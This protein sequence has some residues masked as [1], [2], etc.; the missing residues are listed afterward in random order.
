MTRF[1]ANYVSNTFLN[2]F[3]STLLGSIRTGKAGAQKR[4]ISNTGNVLSLLSCRTSAAKRWARLDELHVL[5]CASKYAPSARSLDIGRKSHSSGKFA[6]S[7][8]TFLHR[9][10]NRRKEGRSRCEGRNGRGFSL[11]HTFEL[12]FH[13]RQAAG[14]NARQSHAASN[15]GAGSRLFAFATGSTTYHHHIVRGKKS[16]FSVSAMFTSQEQDGAG[17]RAALEQQ[18]QYQH[19]VTICNHK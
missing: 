18:I 19:T 16:V 2:H 9:P 11:A 5:L 14:K 17:E 1:S 15:I 6:K 10:P 12:N 7:L 8:K 4:K 13:H 3:R